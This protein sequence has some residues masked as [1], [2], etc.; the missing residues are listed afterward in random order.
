MTTVNAQGIIDP[1]VLEAEFNA[2]R[3]KANAKRKPHIFKSPSAKKWYVVIPDIFLPEVEFTQLM[4]ALAVSRR[5][6]S[7]LN[8]AGT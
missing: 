5:F 6:T 4:A 1:K 8:M 2:L 3:D 7:K